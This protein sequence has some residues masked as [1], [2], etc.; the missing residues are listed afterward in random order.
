M[1]VTVHLECLKGLQAQCEQGII[2][3]EMSWQRNLCWNI[4]MK[5][6]LITSLKE[7]MPFGTLTFVQKTGKLFVLDG[8]QRLSTMMSFINN[9]FEDTDDKLFSE[10]DE[11][12]QRGFCRDN[13]VAYQKVLLEDG[14]GHADEVKLFQM[15]NTQG[16]KLTDGELLA[17]C[18][19]EPIVKLTTDIFLTEN[20]SEFATQLRERWTEV[21]NPDEIHVK[22][23][24]IGQVKTILRNH[25]M[26]DDGEIEQLRTR[27]NGNEDALAEY[28][29]KLKET[30]EFLYPI[31]R[32][33]NK[34]EMAF[35][36]P[37]VLSGC[38][39]N[40]NAISTSFARLVDNG[41]GSIPVADSVRSFS[42]R[43]DDF[44]NFAEDEPHAFGRPKNGFPHLGLI[45]AVWSIIIKATC[46]D[47]PTS[48]TTLYDNGNFGPLKIFYSNLRQHTELQ[49]EYDTFRRKNR[50]KQNL[51]K[52]IQF[53]LANSD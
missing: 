42:Q 16:K 23:L 19:H 38:T 8:K 15:L 10:W 48:C 1:I 43:L 11:R 17:S 9:E 50:N 39:G 18:E 34:G 41:L 49:L 51:M 52:E 46:S 3:T 21:F 6:R 37:L 36:I 4:T 20:P 2:D 14:E 26:S 24:N 32:L 53:I 45:S 30:N 13:I 7:R 27:I 29:N 33:P 35:F 28:K 22:D 5:R 31:K 47:S 12:D 40:L 44:M 25:S